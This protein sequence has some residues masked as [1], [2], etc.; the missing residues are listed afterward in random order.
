[1]SL[2]NRAA[3]RGGV[4]E[5]D[6]RGAVARREDLAHEAFGG[7]A[8][9]REL[10]EHRGRSVDH[11]AGMDRRVVDRL[12][13]ADLL[14]GAVLQDPDLGLR[15]ARD[16]AAAPVEDAGVE[17]DEVDVDG[18]RVLGAGEQAEVLRGDSVVEIGDGAEVGDPPAA[19][20]LERHRPR[21]TVQGRET[22]LVEP[23]LESLERL[24]LRQIDA[25]TCFDARARGRGALRLDDPNRET[26]RPAVEHELVVGHRDAGGVIGDSGEPPQARHAAELDVDRERRAP[27][28]EQR[29]AVEGEVD[30]LGHEPFDDRFDTQPAGDQAI[31]RREQA[32]LR[33][34]DF[35]AGGRGRN[36]AGR[37]I[38]R[39]DCIACG[40]RSPA[41]TESPAA[42]ES[43]AM[44]GAGGSP[45]TSA[46]EGTSS[47]CSTR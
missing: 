3:S 13:T 14:L 47:G 27:L 18:E 6:H 45:G 15:E 38:G 5:G 9:V 21:R 17:L 22:L 1:M 46:G 36:G 19:R 23:E 10:L 7:D 12:E 29:L 35:A 39:G 33:L 34:D 44:F 20:R 8:R 42:R 40:D 28:G 43:A 37:R 4:G 32:K 25:G 26:M 31:D 24:A 11:Y 41:V 30:T 16:R 2:V